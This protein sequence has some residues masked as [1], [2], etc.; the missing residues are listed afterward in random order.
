VFAGDDDAATGML[1]AL[2][3]AGLCV[4]EDVKVVGFDDSTV[5]RFLSPPLT[6]VRA[7]IESVGREAIR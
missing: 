1:S 5:A 7:P 6:T 4:L 2:H 3:R